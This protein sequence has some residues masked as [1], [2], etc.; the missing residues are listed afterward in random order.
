MDEIDFLVYGA[1]HAMFRS[2]AIDI[3]AKR[4]QLHG[5]ALFI[6]VPPRTGKVRA[7]NVRDFKGIEAETALMDLIEKTRPRELILIFS[8]DFYSAGYSKA[9]LVAGVSRPQA[10][11]TEKSPTEIGRDSIESEV[12]F[13]AELREIGLYCEAIGTRLLIVKQI[14]EATT[15]LPVRDCLRWKKGRAALLRNSSITIDQYYARQRQSNVIFR[16]LDKLP[17]KVMD[18]GP[19]FFHRRWS[20]DDCRFGKVHIPRC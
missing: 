12:L 20:L 18:P 3:V 19:T 2:Y 16:S 14:P 15:I 10:I 6:Q 1:S 13:A 8:W 7:G 17:I 4:Y 5:K 11:S 9:E